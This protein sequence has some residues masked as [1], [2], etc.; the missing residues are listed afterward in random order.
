MRLGA[1]FNPTGHHVASW[2]HPDAQ[3]DAGVNFAHYVE[4]AQTAERGKFD[5]VFFADNV[6]VREARP[7][8]LSRSAQYIANFE[9]LT[10]M[11]GLAAV[12]RRIGFVS[13]AST[14]WNEP[15]N[16]AR[17]FASLDHI[18]GG[19]VAWNIVTS[20][21]DGEA[22]N[23][24]RDRI[25]DHALRYERAREFTNVVCDLWDSWADDAF[26]RDKE[27]GLFFD[28]AKVR[29]LDHRGRF[30][31][32]AG[33]LNVPRPPQGHPVLVQAGSSNDG[34]AF[35]A[36]FAEAVFG[37]PLTIEWA[38]GYYADLKQRAA[39]FGR[40]PESILIM[41]G[42]STYVGRT[43]KEAQEL[44]DEMQ[45]RVDPVVGIEMLSAVLGV[46]VSGYPID[47]PLPELDRS[48]V[49]SQA[50]FDN[51]TE[52][53]RN[54]KLS[55]RE[56]CLRVVGARGKSV[57]VG[58]AVQIADHMQTWFENGAAD[59]FNIM[60][61]YLPGQHDAFVDLV[62]PELQERGIFRTEYE[63]TTLRENLG[64]ARPERKPRREAAHV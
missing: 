20:S 25:E 14:S 34:R 30:Y 8:A 58:S 31:S 19:R 39:T 28:P 35:A 59:G 42:I 6:N 55:I 29:P 57:I 60:A 38:Q 22:R 53:A 49:G 56:L 63:G 4:L 44:Y 3:A 48:H 54:E 40:A 52:L 46:D 21:V 24:G 50:S 27:S 43:A 13:T 36:E 64:L 12:T 61:P 32:V 18:S 15:Y 26:L 17:K 7:E 1:F 9:P 16:I 11:A 51:W 62:I 41:P 45:A 23:F 47:G 2:R 5:F 33:P 37:N 10:L